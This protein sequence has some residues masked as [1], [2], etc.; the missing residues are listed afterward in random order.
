MAPSGCYWRCHITSSDNI[1]GNGWEPKD[2]NK[3]IALY[4]SGDEDKYFGWSDASGK[5][6]RQL[7]SLFV[8]RF[9]E[10]ASKGAGWDW[11]YA[12][13]Y[14]AMLGAA[15]AGDF[16]VYFADYDV[17]LPEVGLPPGPQQ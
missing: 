8:E 14:V 4:T 11:V 10:I 3:G 6:A 9:P 1:R 2:W 16:P 17:D 15:E 5:S 13:W 7:A 12:G